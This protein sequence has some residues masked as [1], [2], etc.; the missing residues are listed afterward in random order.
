LIATQQATDKAPTD[1]QA[2]IALLRCEAARSWKSVATSSL[3]MVDSKAPCVR[4][5]RG[6]ARPYS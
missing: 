1:A 4:C 3:A 2:V 6:H 5:A